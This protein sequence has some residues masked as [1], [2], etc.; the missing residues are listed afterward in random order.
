M[1]G[2][3]AGN[4]NMQEFFAPL[5]TVLIIR[6]YSQ[7]EGNAFWTVSRPGN[8]FYLFAYFVLCIFFSV[9]AVNA[10]MLHVEK[11]VRTCRQK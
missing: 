1:G 2:K 4:L 3:R 11:S 8:G 10:K 6:L 5:C 9:F 7:D